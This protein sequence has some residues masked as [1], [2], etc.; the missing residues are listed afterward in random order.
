MGEEFIGKGL[1]FPLQT[2]AT[3]GLALVAREREIEEAIRM[4]LA[5]EAMHGVARR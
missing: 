4:V 3:G 1:A 2:D 5:G